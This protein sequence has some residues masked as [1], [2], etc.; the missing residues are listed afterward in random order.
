VERR[1]DD[2]V[3]LHF[4]ERAYWLWQTGHRLGDLRR[5]IRDYGRDPETVFPSASYHKGGGY[6]TDVNFPVPIDEENNPNFEECLD[7]NP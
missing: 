4:K 1:L 7:R 3:D 2:F 5:L 6:G